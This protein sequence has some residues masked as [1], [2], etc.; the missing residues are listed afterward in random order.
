MKIKTKKNSDIQITLSE[1]E[2]EGLQRI[3]VTSK[4][5][6][7]ELDRLNIGDEC[8][9]VKIAEEL[10]TVCSDFLVDLHDDFTCIH[11]QNIHDYVS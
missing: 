9:T 2:F 3:I 4:T 1:L 10:E 8:L 5:L 11:I 6:N 7:Y